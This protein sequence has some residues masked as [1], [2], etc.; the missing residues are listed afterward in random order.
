MHVG[1]RGLGIVLVV[2][3]YVCRATVRSNFDCY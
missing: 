3:K 1:Y 2:V